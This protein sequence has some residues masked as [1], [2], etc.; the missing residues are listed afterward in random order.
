MSD[1]PVLRALSFKVPADLDAEGRAELARLDALLAKAKEG[2]LSVGQRRDL[3]VLRVRF[4]CCAVLCK[5]E[6]RDGRPAVVV[7][8]E[9]DV[10]VE[11]IQQL[12]DI[13]GVDEREV[14]RWEAAPGWP[15]RARLGGGR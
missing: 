2:R 4:G 14:R 6:V 3:A 12:A 1:V 15:G 10:A 13:F 11:T 7:P 9:Y 5:V 8:G